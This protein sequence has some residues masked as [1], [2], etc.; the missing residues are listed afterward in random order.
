MG[1]VR[2]GNVYAWA[3]ANMKNDEID[4]YQSDLYVKITPKSRK[5][6][7]TLWDT[8]YSRPKSF[9]SQIDGELWYEFPLCALGVYVASRVQKRFRYGIKNPETGQEKMFDDPDKA[10]AYAMKF[11]KGRKARFT[12]IS[13]KAD[14]KIVGRIYMKEGVLVYKGAK[15]GSEIRSLLSDGGLG[16]RW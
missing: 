3:K 11:F 2:P 16:K 13:L 8:D 10:R 5:M 4:T 6:I 9:R 15:E 1:K 12:R 7:E 14:G